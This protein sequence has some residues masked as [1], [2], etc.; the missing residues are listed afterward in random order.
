MKSELIDPQSVLFRS[1]P[2][3]GLLAGLRYAPNSPVAVRTRWMDSYH[4]QP[5]GSGDR[6]LAGPSIFAVTRVPKAHALAISHRI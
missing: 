1:L 5:P 4:L 6:E 2:E 3:Q